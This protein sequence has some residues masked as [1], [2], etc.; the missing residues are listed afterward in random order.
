MLYRRMGVLMAL[1][2]MCVSA[3]ALAET[4]VFPSAG[5]KFAAADGETVV[6]GQ[7]GAGGEIFSVRTVSG[8][9]IALSVAEAP[10]ASRDALLDAYRDGFYQAASRTSQNAISARSAYLDPQ[11]E[12][13]LRLTDVEIRDGV[14]YTF[15]ADMAPAQPAD[16]AEAALRAELDSLKDR[17]AFLSER[18]INPANPA[19]AADNGDGDGGARLLRR[20]GG[21]AVEAVD[22][23]AWVGGRTVHFTVSTEPGANVLASTDGSPQV[24]AQADDSGQ[25]ALTLDLGE[26]EGAHIISLLASAADKAGAAEY[27]LLLADRTA[28]VLLRASEKAVSSG[29]FD[30]YVYSLPGAA[31]ELTTPF[32]TMK[33]RV[34]SQGFMFFS[35]SIK[36]G[37]ENAYIAKA[38]IDGRQ[39]GEA[40]LT[41]R[42]E[43]L[44]SEKA[45]DFR[46]TAQ[47]IPYKRISDNP[48]VYANRSVEIRGKVERVGEANGYPTLI[49]NTSNPKSGVWGDPVYVACRALLNFQEG[50]VMTVLGVSRAQTYRYNG[51]DIPVIEGAFYLK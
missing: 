13:V 24:F 45:A 47:A 38:D 37:A 51:N 50:D 46:Q 42:R 41:L 12:P 7:G 21:V 16:A 33:G 40:R 30:L 25:C 14:A 36:R 32:S 26:E 49:L 29:S 44:Q 6:P 5:V 34:N 35:L 15:T 9:R 28:P 48:S 3:P 31:I 39:P 17:L 2:A 10:D 8:A 1:C 4:Y 23:P 11:G 43:D 22:L 27:E 18:Y 19:T 20:A